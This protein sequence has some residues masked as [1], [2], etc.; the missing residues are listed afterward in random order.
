MENKGRPVPI[1]KFQEYFNHAGLMRMDNKESK[2]YINGYEAAISEL[3]EEIYG[4]L[5]F[6]AR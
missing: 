6:Y 2:E 3:V 4:D 5:L 1:E